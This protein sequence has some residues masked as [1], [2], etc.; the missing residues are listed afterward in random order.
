MALRLPQ[1]AEGIAPKSDD[2]ISIP[3]TYMY[4]ERTDTYKLSSDLHLYTW[5]TPTHMQTQI[6][7]WFVL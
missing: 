3:R 1:Q 6:S 7:K 2:P 5:H 4:K